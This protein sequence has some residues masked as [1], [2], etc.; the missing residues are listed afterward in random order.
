MDL[1]VRMMAK[2]KSDMFTQDDFEYRLYL[3]DYW[4]ALRDSAQVVN[5]NANDMATY[6]Y[7]PKEFLVSKGHPVAG[8]WLLLWLNCIQ[9]REHFKGLK[10][11]LIPNWSQIEDLYSQY[12]TLR[13]REGTVQK[14]LANARL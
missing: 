12:R 2:Q 3:Q 8:D 14:N 13:S 11:I 6:E 5:M 9:D 10:Q 7:R 4:H 1:L